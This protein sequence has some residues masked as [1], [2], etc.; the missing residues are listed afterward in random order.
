MKKYGDSL[1]SKRRFSIIAIV[2]IL[3]SIPLAVFSLLN[4]ESFDV[5][6]RAADLTTDVETCLIR[7]PYVNPETIQVGSTVQSNVSAKT[8]NEAITK[9]LIMN[10]AGETVFTKD[11]T[12]GRDYISENFTITSGETGV[13]GLLGTLTTD[14]GTRPCV[15]ENNKEVTV[16]AQNSAPVFTSLPTSATGKNVIRV[17]Q[18]YQYQLEATDSDKDTINFVFS[19]T[20]NATWLKN[21]VIE[22]GSDGKL[23]L[24]FTG[25]PDEPGSYLA[26][27]FIHDG[28]TSHLAAQTWVI[29]VD[30][31]QNDVP[32]V[33]ITAPTSQRNLE[34][35]DKIKV[36]WEVSDLNQIVKFEL[37]VA[38]NPGNPNT[39]K[40]ISSNL[41]PKVGSYIYDTKNLDAGTYQFV[42]KATDNFNPAATGVGFSAKIV[43][44]GAPDDSDK[45]DDGPIISEPQITNISPADASNIR[46]KIA[47]I[48]ASL[49][50]S[51]GATIVKS[52]IKILLDD[53][54]ITA[55][56]RLNEV[57]NSEYSII[58]T[59]EEEYSEGSHKVTVSF[60]DS[61]KNKAEKSWTFTIVAEDK[62]S[63]V[64]KIFGLEIPKRLAYIIAGG[65]AIVFLAIIVPW[66]LYLAWK[67]NKQQDYS[68]EY[69]NIKAPSPSNI[70]VYEAKPAPV[71]PAVVQKK[72]EV[73]SPTFNVEIPSKGQAQ[74]PIITETIP[75]VVEQ[76]SV[77][78]ETIE[79]EVEEETTKELEALAE[80]LRQKEEMVAGFTGSTPP[81][82]P[83]SSTPPSDTQ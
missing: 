6:N 19:F 49:I 76:A 37:F 62:D 65:L 18:S 32:K 28:Y 23:T 66:L 82:S 13:F 68:I 11:Y 24:K 44:A 54:D 79:D 21:T 48:S 38:T 35:G 39:W 51:K 63:D 33:T 27:V 41:G 57:L 45:P 31:D 1:K 46:N 42:V 5:R 80:R 81:A 30:Q 50:P 4:I 14:Q 47:S 26:N 52:S 56:T 9:V 2:F 22:N 40:T 7:F 17:N 71:K 8:P 16:L 67:G 36:S 15:V 29:N 74:K 25:T 83:Q 43:I 20:P 72:P 3:I 12:D 69:E 60:E 78:E 70:P 55:K 61:K 53:G 34:K 73:K 75:P 64:F 59:P 10:R 58:Y 77:T